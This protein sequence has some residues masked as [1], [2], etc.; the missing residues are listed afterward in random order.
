MKKLFSI[1]LLIFILGCVQEIPKEGFCGRSTYKECS[2]DGDCKIGGCS[3]QICGG[4]DEELIS[5]CEWTE[6]YDAKKYSVE[7]KCVDNKCQWS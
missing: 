7:C 6:C 3:S 1:L 2:V 4:K 5:T